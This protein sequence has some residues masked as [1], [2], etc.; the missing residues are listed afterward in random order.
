MASQMT[1]IECWVIV[2]LGCEPPGLYENPRNM[3]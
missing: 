2:L 1:Y 3:G